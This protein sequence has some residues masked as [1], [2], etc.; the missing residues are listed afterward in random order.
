MKSEIYHLQALS[1]LHCGTGQSAG[2][3]DLPIARDRASNLPLVPGSSVRGVLREAITAQNQQLAT[4]LFGP[5]RVQATTGAFA[6]ALALGDAHLLLLPVRAL[7]GIIAYVTCPFILK[8]YARDVGA[9]AAIPHPVGD[10]EALCTTK[11]VNQLSKKIVLEDLDLDAKI[12]HDVERWAQ[13]IAGIVFANDPVAQQDLIARMVVLPDNVFAFLA[14]T[15]TEVRT[16]IAINQTTGVVSKGALW[17]EENLPAETILWGVY[18]L[19]DSKDSSHKATAAQL[20]QSVPANAL[21][22]LGGH[23]G[24]GRGLVQFIS[25]GSAAA[26]VKAPTREAQL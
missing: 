12:S 23:A 22:Q 16:R 3:V 14:E 7:V 19:A 1:A 25:S 13:S 4:A 24:V 18:A 26:Q 8:R 2:L 11:N 17:T 6:G 9:V 5:E 15:A 10:L 20:K 21:L